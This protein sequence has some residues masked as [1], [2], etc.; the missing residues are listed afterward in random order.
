MGKTYGS[1]PAGRP[2]DLIGKPITHRLA[3]VPTTTVGVRVIPEGGA[4]MAKAESN[5]SYVINGNEFV[6][7]KGGDLP[8]GAQFIAGV[9]DPDPD[10]EPVQARSQKAAP[11]N[12]AR[13]IAP[14]T[15]AK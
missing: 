1:D 10:A 2:A 4:A 14:E 3:P 5:G 15:K 9:A 11:E 13:T 7:R 8:E 12:K 6:I